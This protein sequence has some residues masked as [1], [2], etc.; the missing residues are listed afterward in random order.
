M[1]RDDALAVKQALTGIAEVLTALGLDRGWINNRRGKLILCPGHRESVP[2]CGVTL[3]DSGTIRVHCF[4][5]CGFRGDVF[6]LIAQVYGLDPERDFAEVL[7]IGA[8]LAGITL[9]A[10][11]GGAAE[12]APRLRLLP[13]LP[14]AGS[15]APLPTPTATLEEEI[16]IGR[17]VDVLSDRF[18]IGSD[19][20]IAGG[21]GE[22]LLLEE[23][24]SER[25]AVLPKTGLVT[26]FDVP[27]LA[28]LRPIVIRQNDA[29]HDF[30]LYRDHR[31]V[32]PWRRPDGRVWSFQ[33]R[34]SPKDGTE[35]P[36]TLGAGT[37]SAGGKK[38]HIPKFVWPSA[39]DYQPRECFPWGV[40][41]YEAYDKATE[42]AW[43]TEGASDAASLRVLNRM[44]LL[45]KDGSGRKMVALG[46]PGVQTLDTYAAALGPLTRGR[47]GFVG[48]DN[49]GAGQSVAQGWQAMQLS[50]GARESVIKIPSQKDWNKYL[51]ANR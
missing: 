50:L 6:S 41:A 8:D 32:I 46:L 45:T 29:G 37:P 31:L 26:L 5:Q 13:P 47:R 22:R 35:D 16:A 27:E 33:R 51:Q 39:A 48:V 44:G 10:P 3:G 18:P 25:W 42:E 2:S 11:P 23:A 28:A 7:A 21:L 20:G 12:R 17:A 43:W 19:P 49:D 34:F 24:K 1:S 40:D 36:K 15:A 9:A 4:S 14:P 38:R 30:A